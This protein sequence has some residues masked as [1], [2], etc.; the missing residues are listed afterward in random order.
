MSI[1]QVGSGSSDRP[2]SDQFIRYG[3]ALIGPGDSGNYRVHGSDDEFVKSFVRDVKP[4]DRIVLREGRRRIKAIGIV[5][6]KEQPSAFA[7]QAH[8]PV[9][10]S[11]VYLPQ[12]D[13]EEG[14]DLQ[15]GH[16]V[17][18]TIVDKVLNRDAFGSV[19]SRFSG[20]YDN[21]VVSLV[22]ETSL[23]GNPALL[24]ELPPIN[25]TLTSDEIGNQLFRRGLSQHNVERTIAVIEQIC[26]LRNWYQQTKQWPQEQEAIAY[27]V[28]PFLLALGWSEQ[29]TAV[30]WN[31]ID[32]ALFSRGERTKENCKIVVE[33]KRNDSGLAWAID[34]AR[35]YINGLG[36]LNCSRCLVTDG[37]R[38]RIVNAI[39]RNDGTDISVYANLT[40][41]KDVGLILDLIP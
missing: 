34:Q 11:Y 8:Y 9:S 28:V 2:L 24:P 22:N 36:L 32:I 18:W 20:I 33:V 25:S 39:P 27:M 14:W 37:V 21:E 38:Y 41:I 40:R 35:G 12:F 17:C 26:R 29:Q 5:V 3:V 1:W 23:N 31:R 4:G 15:H 10:D 30:Q 13:D 19:P 16:R 7:D 6:V